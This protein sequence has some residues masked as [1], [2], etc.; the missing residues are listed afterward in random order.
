MTAVTAQR[1]TQLSKSYRVA[2]VLTTLIVLLGVVAAAGGLFLP[3]LYR[4]NSYMS[5]QAIGQDL[6]TLVVAIPA[7]VVTLAFVRRGSARA[8]LVWVGLLSYMC[9]TYTTYAFGSTFNPFF[10]I[11]V[12]LFSLSIASLIAV[13]G[14]IDAPA[15]LRRFDAGTPRVA[16]AVFLVLVGVMVAGLWLP[17]ILGYLGTGVLPETLVLSGLPTNF[18][19]VMDLGLVLPLSL[20]TAALLLR[21]EA[22]GYVLAGVILTK[23]M[24]MGLAMLSMV[25]FMVRDGQALEVPPTVM[26]SVVT[27]GGLGLSAW[28]FR[29]CKG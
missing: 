28:F 26:A 15:W 7:L 29:H 8:R 18:V 20:L 12:A 6:V 27:L 24:T 25:W 21:R 13:L 17:P 9:Y 22:W 1:G 11:Y 4:D 5:S 23:A 19:Y 3:G 16:V 14:A 2:M 10:L